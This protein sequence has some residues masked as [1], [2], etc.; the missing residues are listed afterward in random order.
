MSM[1]L[2]VDEGL[3]TFGSMIRAARLARQLT[4][5]E[6]ARA[7][8]VSLAQ[9]ALF[10]KGRNVSL[11]FLLKVA[12]ALDLSLSVG[13]TG[14]SASPLGG[15][16]VFELVRITDLFAALVEHLRGFA[17]NAVLPPSERGKLRDAH[18][19]EEFIARHA[20]DEEGVARLA[21]A[22]EKL[23]NEADARDRTKPPAPVTKVVK[24]R[25]RK[26]EE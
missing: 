20:R 6:L 2:S 16:D 21:A 18:A 14:H 24:K 4:Q 17:T 23:S 25:A 12:N 15:L 10:E 1:T 3:R 5:A 13:G 8:G 9:L 11:L 22:L 19:V 26:G 7:A